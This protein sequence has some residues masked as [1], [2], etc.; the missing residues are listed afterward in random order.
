MKNILVLVN[1]KL[2]IDHPEPIIIWLF[3]HSNTLNV[4]LSIST[5]R[6]TF[7]AAFEVFY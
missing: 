2:L 1:S 4:N 6:K 3:A 7:L 5:N